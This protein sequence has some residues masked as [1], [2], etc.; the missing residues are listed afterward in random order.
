MLKA[1][2]RVGT[3]VASEAGPILEA[4]LLW[5]SENPIVPTDEQSLAV[6]GLKRAF[7]FDAH[8]WVRWGAVEWQRRMFLAPEPEVPEEARKFMWSS[9]VDGVSEDQ[10]I[11]HNCIVVN[12]FVAGQKAGK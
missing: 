1:A 2:C 8:E 6:V 7:P 11:N 4:A 5:L 10:R 9:P 3:T 12:A